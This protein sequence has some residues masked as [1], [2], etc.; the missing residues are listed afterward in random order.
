MAEMMSGAAFGGRV[1]GA[2]TNAQVNATG[3][4]GIDQPL[5]KKKKFARRFEKR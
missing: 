5:N 1:S 3:M 2:G 4:A